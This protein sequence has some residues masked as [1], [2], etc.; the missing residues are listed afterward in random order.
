MK[1]NIFSLILAALALLFVGT[2][3]EKEFPTQLNHELST[4]TD[5]SE[6]LPV[7]EYGAV[8]LGSFNV[9]YGA[10]SD[11]DNYKWN[12][13]KTVLAEAI[14]ANDFDIVGL[15]EVDK[16][17][18]QQLPGLISA[19]L[20]QGSTRN[21]QYWFMNRDKQNADADESL[22][23]AGEGLGVMWDA[24]KFTISDQHYYWLSPTPDVMSTG[25]DETG[26]R[27]MAC[28]AVFTSVADP[29]K[30]FFL[31]VVHAPLAQTAR[32][33]SA[34][35]LNAKEAEYNVAGLAS[36]MVG[37]MNCTPEQDPAKTF[38]G[39]LGWKDAFNEVPIA[40]KVGGTITFHSKKDITDTTNP[41]NRIDYILYKN[42]PE[43]LTYKVDY[44]KYGGYY[45]SDHCPISV[46]FNIPDPAKPVP[47]GLSGAGTEVNPFKVANAADWGTVANFVNTNGDKVDGY[48]YK[49]TGD[50]AFAGDFVRITSFHG[51]LDGDGHKLTGITGEAAEAIFGGIINE[52]PD[53]GVVRNLHVESTLSSAFANLG[54][55]VGVAREGSLIDG[56]TYKGDLTGTGAAARIGGIV[57]T[58]YG[59]IVNC[60]CLGGNFVAG[61]ATKSENMGGIAGRIENASGATRPSVMANCYSW[62]DKIVS[63][64]NNIGGVTGGLGSAA[65]C[66]NVYGITADITAAGT[67]GSCIGYSK[68]GNI[69]N[70]YAND[71][72]AF[73][74]SGTKWVANDKQASDWTTCGAALTLANMKAGAVTLPSSGA[75]CADFVAALNAGI[76]DWNALVKLDAMTGN[77]ETTPYGVLNKPDVT[78]R[79]WEFDATTGY[80]VLKASS[81]TGPAIVTVKIV[82]K[83]YGEANGWIT[84]GTKMYTEVTQGGVTLTAGG[85]DG[86]E[87]GVYNIPSYYDWRFYQARGGKLTISVPAG[88][89]LVSVMFDNYEYK[90]G[91]CFYDE[92]GNP[93]L[94][95]TELEVTGESAVFVV[96]SQT[97]ATNGQARIL[98]VTVKYV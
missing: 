75:E 80:P 26:Y 19:A 48:V 33:N 29:T 28:C 89:S 55:V 92:K 82:F 69:R 36:F 7:I 65:Y 14:V 32:T 77:K 40:S 91:G 79:E 13:R 68:I 10:Y 78:L 5:V 87:N 86:T 1:K 20:P 23:A 96:G 12:V 95:D 2:A 31:T 50:I 17:V 37:D 57:G 43:V 49:L 22:S 51:I 67:Y 88:C 74:G 9:L 52:L 39:T 93:G 66:V 8:K 73:A 72:A 70:V 35:V 27:R 60:G 15:Q 16:T 81:S 64:N 4:D 62:L 41:E 94:N 21:Y 71:A 85:N 6:W 76:A 34:G 47:A 30:Q 3:C 97:G 46:T 44:N 90:N 45:P 98:G 42:K 56:V 58:G 38:V 24:N 54:G 18:R 25:W 84:D 61:S 11:N 59:V 63:S 83:D 53:G